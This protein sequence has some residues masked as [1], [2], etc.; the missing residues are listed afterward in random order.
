MF[1]EV[2]IVL[3]P[4]KK[5]FFF[6]FLWKPG[7]L[8]E[9]IAV[10]QEQTLNCNPQGTLCLR[11]QEVPLVVRPGSC[12]QKADDTNVSRWLHDCLG[13][14][15]FL[16]DWLLWEMLGKMRRNK[17]NMGAGGQLVNSCDCGSYVLGSDLI[18]SMPFF[19]LYILLDRE[20]YFWCDVVVADGSA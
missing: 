10:D 6:C 7:N 18:S 14:F 2:R 20:G 15:F 9:P 11:N 16:L 8:Q 3:E 17:G 5:V 13:F 12:I 19:F 1:H 4:G